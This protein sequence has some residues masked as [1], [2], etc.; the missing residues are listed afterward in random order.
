MVQQVRDY[1]R[2]N[3]G[4]VYFDDISDSFIE[5]YLSRPYIVDLSFEIQM[6]YLYDAVMS[7]LMVD[8]DE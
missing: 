8:Y 6:N 4:F 2:Q 1:F 3:Y 5:E 7:Q